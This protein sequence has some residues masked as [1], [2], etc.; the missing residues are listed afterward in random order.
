MCTAH[1][2][3][4]EF[5]TA[6]VSSFKPD[7]RADALRRSAGAEFISINTEGFVPMNNSPDLVTGWTGFK[8][9]SVTFFSSQ[10][11]ENPNGNSR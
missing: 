5:E 3:N 11:K 7:G 10:M 8:S 2:K 1:W 9:C 6:D 4:T